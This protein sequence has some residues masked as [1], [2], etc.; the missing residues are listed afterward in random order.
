MNTVSLRL[1]ALALVAV[2]SLAFAG[3]AEA[4]PDK[5]GDCPGQ[6]PPLTQ[7]QHDGIQ[8]LNQDFMANT[9]GLRQALMVKKAELNAQLI[10]P[11][12]DTAKVESLSRE[13]G[14]LRGKMLAARLNYKAELAKLGVSFKGCPVT[15]EGWGPRGHGR[16]FHD[17]GCPGSDCER[18]PRG[19]FGKHEARGPRGPHG[20]CWR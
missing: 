2:C 16:S 13:I 1:G 10:S 18:G 14:E 8:K 11:T 19:H 9:L 15:G 6:K 5:A 20:D 3:L 4:R 12:P 17:D 7:E